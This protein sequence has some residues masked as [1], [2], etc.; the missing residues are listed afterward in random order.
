LSSA[1]AGC[2]GTV[3]KE[4]GK[5]SGVGEE[6]HGEN[7]GRCLGVCGGRREVEVVKDEYQ[8]TRER[9]D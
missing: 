3:A 9:G 4:A 7:G 8:T 6:D 5:T 2:G 1:S